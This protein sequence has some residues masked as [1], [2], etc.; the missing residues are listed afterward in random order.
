MADVT[1]LRAAGGGLVAGLSVGA[2]DAVTVVLAIQNMTPLSPVW[3]A[4]RE[5][6]KPGGVVIVVMMHPCFRVPRQSDWYWEEA[7]G[8][9][10]ARLVR[11]YLTSTPVAIQMHPGLAAYGKDDATTTHFHRPL[12]AYVN[13]LGNAGLLIDH[14]EEWPSH[15][16]SQPGPRQA[17]LDRA[18]K[19]IP[20]FL[21]LRAR[22]V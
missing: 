10:Q 13:T 21:A 3:Q 20:M 19:E 15:K 16:K 9:V 18:R 4:C 22:K 14:I 17:A 5:V 12:Q 1:K 11:Q 7:G 2:F 8:G 6:L